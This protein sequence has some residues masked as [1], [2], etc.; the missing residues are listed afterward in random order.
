MHACP[1]NGWI[2]LSIIVWNF[3]YHL[4]PQKRHPVL[5]FLVVN[6]N[7]EES[8]FKDE[9]TGNAEKS[10]ATDAAPVAIAEAT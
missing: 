6:Q 9:E 1:C 2:S 5:L 8:V 7:Q 3:N 4:W 10:D